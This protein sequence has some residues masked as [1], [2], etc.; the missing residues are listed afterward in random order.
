MNEAAAAGVPIVLTTIELPGVTRIQEASNKA[1]AKLQREDKKVRISLISTDEEVVCQ[2]GDTVQV[3][4]TYRG[5]DAPVWV[6]SSRMTSYGRFQITGTIYR[7]RQYPDEDYTDGG[8]LY[9]EGYTPVV[10]VDP[11]PPIEEECQPYSCSALA[12]GQEQGLV[13]AGAVGS[14]MWDLLDYQDNTAQIP[15]YFRTVGAG[16]GWNLTCTNSL[17]SWTAG[18]IKSSL[19]VPANGDI[20]ACNP[21]TNPRCCS[22]VNSAPNS[23]WWVAN[24]TAWGSKL[25]NVNM[26]VVSRGMGS[27][28]GNQK[29]RL[30]LGYGKFGHYTQTAYTSNGSFDVNCWGGRSSDNLNDVLI[31]NLGKGAWQ[32]TFTLPLGLLTSSEPVLVQIELA[33]SDIDYPASSYQG[34]YY[35]SYDMK[36]TMTASYRITKKDGT[37]AD[38]TYSYYGRINQVFDFTHGNGNTRPINEAYK[39]KS[40][41]TTFTN[42][43][44]LGTFSG[45]YNLSIAHEVDGATGVNMGGGNPGGINNSLSVSFTRNYSTYTVPAWCSAP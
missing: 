5:I 26:S 15:Q 38:G 22:N 13:V 27:A 34:Y 44:L 41:P 7:D 28:A 45:L 21:E 35:A 9:L 12:S 16:S 29:S 40:L 10:T 31:F 17:S 32:K 30:F 4:S 14:G 19:L 24:M 43:Y 42:N 1:I 6:E 3:L 20:D 23:V 25:P 36:S 2:P 33:F 8:K 11:E 39:A 18:N 37:V